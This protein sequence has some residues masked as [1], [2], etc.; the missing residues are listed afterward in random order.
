MPEYL[1]LIK[2]DE[3][4]LV[5]MIV[6]VPKTEEAVVS[7]VEAVASSMAGFTYAM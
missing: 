6:D 3:F 1:E 4:S 2:K 5:N 7:K